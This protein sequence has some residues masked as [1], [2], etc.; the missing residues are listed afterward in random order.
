MSTRKDT[1][2]P[3]R[4]PARAGTAAR[5]A[6]I[7]A[8]ALRCFSEQ[9]LDGTTVHDIQRAANC[10]IGSIYHHFG[11]KEGVAEALFIEGVENLNKSMLNKLKPCRSGEACV[12]A[13]VGQYCAWST[14]N[15][16]LARYLHSRDIDF[17]AEAK[18]RLKVIYRDYIGAVF[19]IFGPFVENGEIRLLSVDV[20]VPLI[21]GPI[22]DYVRRW[23]SGDHKVVPRKVEA[24]FAD[25]AWNAVKG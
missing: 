3:T 15:Q 17:S 20:Y 18:A 14:R 13:V 11:S 5:K 21:S 19:G 1:S 8:A 25:A 23:L 16:Q 2:G 6:S 12:R 4:R 22:Q 7:L 10:S 24:L 9:G